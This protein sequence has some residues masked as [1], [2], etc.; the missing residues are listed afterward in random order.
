MRYAVFNANRFLVRWFTGLGDAKA[1]AAA[2]GGDV[3]DFHERPLKWP[4]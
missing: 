2:I 1:L 4:A 3:R